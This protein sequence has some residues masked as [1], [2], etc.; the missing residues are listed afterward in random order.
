MLSDELFSACEIEIPGTC[1]SFP[2]PEE[3]LECARDSDVDN[4]KDGDVH[5]TPTIFCIVVL[6]MVSLLNAM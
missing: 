4:D 6:I 1:K 2:L 3:F 5:V